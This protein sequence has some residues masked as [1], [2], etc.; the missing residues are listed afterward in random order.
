MAMASAPRGVN[1]CDSDCHV[2]RSVWLPPKYLA[3]RISCGIVFGKSKRKPGSSLLFSAPQRQG[4]G[5]QAEAGAGG[6]LCWEVARCGARASPRLMLPPLPEPPGGRGKHAHASPASPPEGRQEKRN[7]LSD[8][9][10]RTRAAFGACHFFWLGGR[11]QGCL[12][13]CVHACAVGAVLAS[14]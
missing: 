9:Q 14:A 4:E 11:L 6:R 3:G 1:S 13:T 5:G 12:W 10:A 7:A 2:A 8:L